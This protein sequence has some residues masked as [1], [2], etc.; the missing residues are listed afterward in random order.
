MPVNKSTLLTKLRDLTANTGYDVVSPV[1]EDI[2]SAALSSETLGDVNINVVN[3][4]DLLPNLAYYDSPAGMLYYVND[5]GVFALSTA[6]KWI[7][8]DGRTLREDLVYGKIWAWGYN[9]RGQLGDDTITSRS[10]PVSVVGGFTDWCQV[11]GG[12]S[13]S[14][15]LRRNGTAWAWGCN[16]IG[17]L[18][19][20]TTTS[21]RSPVL[22][23]G[24]FTDWCQVSIHQHALAIRANGSA[25]AWGFNNSGQLGNDT[26]SNRSSPV[27]VVGGFTDWCQ[28]SAS[29]CHSLGVRENGTA[30]A[31]GSN[32]NGR[33]GDD[34]TTARS[35]PVSVVGGF[36]DWCQVSAGNAHSLAVRCNGTVWAWGSNANGRLGDDTTIS[37]SSPVSVVGGFTDWC[38]VSA[39]DAHSLAVR[40]NGT[41]WAWGSNSSGQLGDDTATSRSSPVSV[42]GGFTD[43]CQVDAGGTQS[44]GLR[45][46]GTAWSW[47]ANS[48]GQLGDDTTTNRSSPVSVVG[49]FN[50]WCQISASGAHSLGVRYK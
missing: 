12:S 45:T 4:I 22:V 5:I 28:V 30:W 33:L 32:A 37:R 29:T 20:G 14:L 17:A 44:F 50:D 39:G 48:S 16:A 34:T 24:G 47:G 42:V 23:V 10:S 40:C 21:R 43:W 27:S 49:G 15:G 8:L 26:V 13:H 2:L 46:N 36:T 11:S 7:T 35:S 3:N 31:W 19:D 41:V 1:V 18:G 38:Q 6:D 25:W 9:G